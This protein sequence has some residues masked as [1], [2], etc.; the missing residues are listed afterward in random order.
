[1]AGSQHHQPD[2]KLSYKKAL[3]KSTAKPFKQ[4]VGYQLWHASDVNL[5]SARGVTCFKRYHLSTSFFTLSFLFDHFVF[6]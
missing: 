5:N 3:L 6:F 2:K 1:L 4:V